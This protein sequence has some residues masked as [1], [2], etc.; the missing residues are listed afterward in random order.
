LIDAMTGAARI[1]AP[2]NAS[3]KNFALTGCRV[4][5]IPASF[6]IILPDCAALVVPDLFM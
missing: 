2:A 3:L 1:D 5:T 6:N 4:S